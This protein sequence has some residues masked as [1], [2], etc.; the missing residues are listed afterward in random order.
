MSVP[1]QGIEAYTT[2]KRLEVTLTSSP[3]DREETELKRWFEDDTSVPSALDTLVIEIYFPL[4]DLTDWCQRRD[5]RAASQLRAIRYRELPSHSVMEVSN[6]LDAVPSLELLAVG[7]RGRLAWAPI[8]WADVPGLANLP[9]LI[10]LALY[11]HKGLRS[12]GLFLVPEY[13]SNCPTMEFPSPPSDAS[14]AE[15]EICVWREPSLWYTWRLA[16]FLAAWLPDTCTVGLQTPGPVPAAFEL[17]M[18]SLRK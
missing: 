4:E 16:S 14:L 17:V 2:R 7:H 11:Q 1:L 6:L 9:A 13:E 5:H 10:D 18:A 15:L 3:I 12:L 8:P